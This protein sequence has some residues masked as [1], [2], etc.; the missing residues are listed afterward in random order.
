MEA[1]ENVFL[2]EGS[3]GQILGTTCA[4]DHLYTCST[5]GSC[6]SL[7]RFLPFPGTHPL[8][9]NTNLA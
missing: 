4:V 2:G 8:R 5:P 1:K 6:L 7:P 9:S 3:G